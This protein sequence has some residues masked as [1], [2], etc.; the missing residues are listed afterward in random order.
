MGSCDVASQR[1]WAL[2]FVCRAAVRLKVIITP[3]ASAYGRSQRTLFMYSY[4]L[5]LYKLELTILVIAR[6]YGGLFHIRYVLTTVYL[7]ARPAIGS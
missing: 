1:A 2:T 4:R 5:Q 7:T 6:T 3:L